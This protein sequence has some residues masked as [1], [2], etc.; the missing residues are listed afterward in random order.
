M[1]GGVRGMPFGRGSGPWLMESQ[2]A[3]ERVRATCCARQRLPPST[4]IHP[5]SPQVPAA[6]AAVSGRGGEA[7]RGAKE[8]EGDGRQVGWGLQRFA[9]LRGGH[10]AG[11]GWAGLECNRVGGRGRNIRGTRGRAG[12]LGEGGCLDGVERAT[13]AAAP[14]LAHV[15]VLGLMPQPPRRSNARACIRCHASGSG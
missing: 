4:C 9:E 1:P 13:D 14:L 8:D 12:G 6:R 10:K 2:H 11:L 15:Y 7:G 3:R 5:R